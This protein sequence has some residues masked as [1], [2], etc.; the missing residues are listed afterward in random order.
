MSKIFYGI[1]S[2]TGWTIHYGCDPG[3]KINVLG[4]AK[5]E[6]ISNYGDFR[7]VHLIRDPRDVIVSGYY[8]H[9]KTHPTNK[10]NELAEFRKKLA[11]VDLY[12]GLFL[13]MDFVAPHLND[14]FL[15]NYNN[16]NILEL[17]FE[18]ITT[19]PDWAATF[20]FLGLW[21]ESDSGSELKYE[22]L[23]TLNKLNNRNL[24]PS[25]FQNLKIP[26]HRLLKLPEQNSFKKL[27]GGRSKGDSNEDSH[28]RKGVSGEWKEVFSEEHKNYFKKQFP[29]LLEKLR[30]ESDDQW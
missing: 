16:P 17:R 4:N 13:E 26:I 30:Y 8:S 7:G 5:L 9:L 19:N 11:S 10:W 14:M 24:F 25:Q 22:L 29:G 27:S 20:E 3:K 6:H 21:S 23:K 15:W 2:A 1:Q 12:E 28:Y 18:E